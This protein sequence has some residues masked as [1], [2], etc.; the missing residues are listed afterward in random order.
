MRDFFKVENLSKSFGRLSALYDVGF[1]IKQG[2]IVGLVGPN[3]AGKTTCLNGICGFFSIDSGKVIFKGKDVTGASTNKL[4]IMGLIRTFQ[5][6]KPFKQLTVYENV[7][8]TTLFNPR[9]K[10]LHVS[11][12]EFVEQI[13]KVVDLYALRE[14]PAGNLNYPNLKRLELARSQ[15]LSP[16]LLLLDEPFSGLSAVEIESESELLKRLVGEGM[17]ML[18]VE[19]KI[20]EL[21][22]LVNRIIV[23]HYGKLIADGTP[24]EVLRNGEVIRVY[25]GKRWGGSRNVT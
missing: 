5:I 14:V 19:H 15:G 22:K 1:S 10:R 3:G 12:R 20:R 9:L 7:A 4:A 11:A 17:T 8:I 24:E 18:V 21:I 13:L 16:E 23:L 25:L 2:E 6:P